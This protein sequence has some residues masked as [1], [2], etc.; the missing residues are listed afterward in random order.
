LFSAFFGFSAG[1]AN[2][3]KDRK[4]YTIAKD[5][6]KGFIRYLGSWVLILYNDKL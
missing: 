6:D 5:K 4:R 1:A 2:S 3:A